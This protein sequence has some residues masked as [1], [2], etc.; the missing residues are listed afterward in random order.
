MDTFLKENQLKQADV[1]LILPP[2]AYIE[3]PSIG[4]HILQA[5]AK[6]QGF[7]VQVGYI[8]MLFAYLLGG[9]T[10]KTMCLSH[11][12]MIGE[13]FFADAAYGTDPFSKSGYDI[14]SCFEKLLSK[15]FDINTVKKIYS[16]LDELLDIITD[17]ILQLNYKVIGCSTTFNQTS[18]S[19]A[20]LNRIKSKNP[21]IITIMGGA[22]CEQKMAKGILSLSDKIDYVFSGKSEC[23]FPNFLK[24]VFTTNL[25]EN[26]VIQSGEPVNVEDIPVMDYTHY[27]EQLHHFSFDT[28]IPK[29]EILLLYETSRGCWWGQKH[30]CNFCG[31]NGDDI[32]FKQKSCDKIISELKI[33]LDKHPSN[34]VVM[35]DSIMPYTFIDT[36]IPMLQKEIPD[37]RLFYEVKSNMPL[38]HLI[39]LKNAGV[40]HMQPGIEG[41]SSSLLKRMSKGTTAKLNVMFLKNVRSLDLDASWNLLYAF[42]GDTKIEYEETLKL[43]PLI[44]HFEPPKACSNIS[45]QRF[46]NYFDQSEEFGITNLMPIPCYNNFLPKNVDANKLAYDFTGEYEHFSRDDEPVMIEIKAIIEKW[47]KSWEGNAIPKLHISKASQKN[48]LLMDTRGLSG[49]KHIQIISYKQALAALKDRPIA[50][51]EN[52]ENEI[53][54]AKEQKLIVELDGW[55]VSLITAEPELLLEFNNNSVA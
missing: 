13:A 7:S 45:L 16:Q 35:V 39:K 3:A 26:K 54:W 37:I 40:F 2:F 11:D 17:Q 32:F 33:L 25:P 51:V 1:L 49:M 18:A 10:Y 44:V 19:I 23:S 20:L 31:L 53:K 5:C 24:D 12:T 38:K 9:E 34:T 41:L 4:L 27:Y 50:Q 55:Y 52:L 46:S 6:E 22:N 36:L 47:Q 30:Q 29:N 48:Y 21:K 42:P 43:L 8:N 14:D 28:K 15:K